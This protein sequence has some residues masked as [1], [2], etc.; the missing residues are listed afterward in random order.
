MLKTLT[1]IWKPTEGQVCWQNENLLTQDRRT[2]SR[3]LSFVPQNSAAPFDFT[4]TEIVAMGRYP[5]GTFRSR[6]GSLE[7]VYETLKLVN[8][9]HLRDRPIS[10]LSSGE[11]QQVYIARALLTESPVLLLDEP[12]ANLDIKHQ[13]EIWKLLVNLKEKGKLVIV[14][15]H[16]LVAIQKYCFHVSI[17]NQG[18]C[19]SFR[20]NFRSDDTRID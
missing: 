6:E 2:I 10:Q 11:R 13:Y 14:A 8:A 15:S 18:C 12:T 5:H 16:D 9:W 20:G 1:G 17:L 3:T 7:K 19:C 4:V